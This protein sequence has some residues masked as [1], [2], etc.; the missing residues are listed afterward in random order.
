MRA[1]RVVFFLLISSAA[2]ATLAQD[3]LQSSD[4]LKL[5]SVSDVEVSPDAT[6][7]AY[8]V[9][10]NDGAGRPYGQLWVMTLAD[11][12]TLRFGGDKEPSGNP[13]WSP[14]GQWIA[15][16]GRVGDK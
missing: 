16:R 1:S 15:Y 10:N 6:R 13:T 5:R 7:V 2:N 14:D 9:E 12:K 8:T 4:L 11:G 3:R